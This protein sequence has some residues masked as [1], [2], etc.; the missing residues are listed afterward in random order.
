[1]N[2]SLNLQQHANGSVLSD[3][4]NISQMNYLWPLNSTLSDWDVSDK[5]IS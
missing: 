1:M 2:F 3:L 5:A 4:R